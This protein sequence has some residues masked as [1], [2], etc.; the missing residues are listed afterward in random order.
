MSKI[1]MLVLLFFGLAFLQGCESES[2]A[3]R[4]SIRQE[5]NTVMVNVTNTNGSITQVMLIKQGPGYIGPRGEYY[6]TLPTENQLRPV[7]GF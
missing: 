7:Y 4:E 1:L 5:M 2:K 3:E 6:E